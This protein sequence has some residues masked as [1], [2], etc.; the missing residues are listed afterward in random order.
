KREVEDALP[1]RRRAP[2]AEQPAAP[3][4]TDASE[5]QPRCI[6]ARVEQPQRC[7]GTDDLESPRRL[8]VVI[9]V[10]GSPGNTGWK[11]HGLAASKGRDDELVNAA[12]ERGGGER[13][14]VVVP[15]D[16][17]HRQSP[18]ESSGRGADK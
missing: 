6:A 15:A 12:V 10:A 4:I 7:V 1:V 2:H 3:G 11:C 8:R 17:P 14:G 5:R 18:I 13:G 9:P 16:G